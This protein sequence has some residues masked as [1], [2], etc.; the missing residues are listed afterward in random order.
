MTSPLTVYAVYTGLCVIAAGCYLYTS[1]M[2]V[3]TQQSVVTYKQ[4]LMRSQE[5]AQDHQLVNYILSRCSECTL[6]KAAHDNV[7]A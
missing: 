1:K 7:C 5:S 3:C 2:F 4:M 6:K